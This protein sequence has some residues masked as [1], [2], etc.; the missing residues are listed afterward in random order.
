MSVSALRESRATQTRREDPNESGM[1]MAGRRIWI[2][3]RATRDDHDILAVMA[4]AI[5]AVL[6]VE[7]KRH[8]R[9]QSDVPKLR[10]F[11]LAVD[12]CAVAIPVKPHR[13]GGRRTV[14]SYGYQPDHR[15]ISK[16]SGYAL[17]EF[18]GHIDERCHAR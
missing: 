7:V 10:R 9:V 6:S 5:S 11:R 3:L 15:I 18:R 4:A 17:A 8:P 2:N 13:T 16:A 14:G 12:K 1:L